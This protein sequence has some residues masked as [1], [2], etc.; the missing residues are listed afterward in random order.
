MS[1]P[2]GVSASYA[3]RIFAD[4]HQIYLED[5]QAVQAGAGEG[6]VPDQQVTA[7]DTLVGQLLS[8]EAKARRVGVAPGVVAI[9]TARNATVLLSVEVVSHPPSDDWRGWDRVV[10]ASLDLPS[11]CLVV[12]GVSDYFPAAP[13]IS[14]APGTYRVR[15]YYGGLETVSSDALE[16][17]DHYKVVLW[18]APA[19]QPVVLF[20]KEGGALQK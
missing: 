11:G 15:A 8:P 1:T 20:A 6:E 14:L 19:A 18:P 10:E 12:H 7:I 4:Y 9:L 3:Y 13:R 2:S 16:G 17:A 5:S